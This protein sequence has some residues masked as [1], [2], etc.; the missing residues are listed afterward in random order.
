[1][2]PTQV[3]AKQHYD[4]MSS[5]MEQIGYRVAYL[6]S[7]MKAKEKRDILADIHSGAIQMIVGTQA[8]ISGTVEYSRL[9][10]TIVDEEHR[11]G[12][13]QRSTL[14][15]KAKDGVHAITMS[16]TPIPRTLAHVI[17]GDTVQL[18]TIRTMPNGRKPVITAMSTGRD[19]IYRF[20]IKQSRL[21]HQAYAVCPMIDKNDDMEGVKSVEEV[22]AEYRAALEP[23][24]VKV[25]TLTGRNSAQETEDTITAFKNGEIDVLVS[26]TVIEVGVNVPTATAIIIHNADR[27]GLSQL[28]QLR[29]R[30]G[31][32]QLQS[33]CVLECENPTEEGKQRLNAMCSTTDGFAIAEA[34][35]K[36]RG[37]GDFIGTK[38]SGD[39]K[40]MSLMLAFPEKY[41]IA[42]K[43]A[44]IILDRGD[45][46]CILAERVA[47]EQDAEQGA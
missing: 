29:G 30:V 6:H 17:Y 15:S 27:F 41:E 46:C 3:L 19:K 9:G 44:A 25:A 31:R 18:L 38:Q 24:G 45:D 39:N 42:K 32:S 34:D 11:F 47:A 36:I 7:G 21:K 8:V 16:A 14:A 40:Y 33:Y 28:H 12:V 20:I 26:T 37:A 22:S 43:T 1:M 4:E 23:Y 2:A 5:L 35:L 13:D 10:L